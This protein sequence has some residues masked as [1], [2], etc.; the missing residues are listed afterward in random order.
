MLADAQ[1]LAER[2]LL[3]ETA[4]TWVNLAD[5]L[6]FLK[7]EPA[8]V[9][10]SERTG[11]RHLYLYGLDGQLRRPLTQGTWNVD[12]LLAVDE[13]AGL[14]YFAS[15]RDALTSRCTRHASMAAPPRAHRISQVDGGTMPLPRTHRVVALYVDTYS[16]ATTRPRSASAGPTAAPPLDRESAQPGI[17][18]QPY[19]EGQS[20]PIRAAQG[21]EPDLQYSRQACRF[22]AK[23]RCRC[24]S[25]SA[26]RPHRMFSGA[27]PR[28]F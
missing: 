13:P 22:R 15:N 24:T 11:T 26:A 10:S 14:L 20:T 5:D 19:H 27:G 4:S 17:P 12:K 2:T 1:T 28:I 8:F 23:R 25:M 21:E 3:S 18:P 9:W 16:G 6:H 7:K